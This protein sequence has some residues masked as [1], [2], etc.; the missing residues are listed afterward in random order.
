MQYLKEEIKNRIISAALNEFKDKGFLGAS[1]RDIAK[2]AGVAIGNV[3]RYFENKDELFNEIMEPVYTEFIALVFNVG[4][5]DDL[6]YNL[7]SQTAKDIADKLME[8]FKKYDV[9]LLIMMDKSKGSKFENLKEELVQLVDTRLK[10][11]LLPKFR[12]NGVQIQDEFI[13]YVIAA[14]FVEGIFIILRNYTD[15]TQIRYL[16]S[17][18]LNLYFVDIVNR[19]K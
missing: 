9:E 18:L 13:T 4:K 14:T 1:M 3:Y 2:N 8:V 15:E 16:T 11:E 10:N 5:S 6:C 7:E 17:Q 12:A 19:W